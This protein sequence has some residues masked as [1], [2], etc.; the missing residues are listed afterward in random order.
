MATV[1]TL[2]AQRSASSAVGTLG[3]MGKLPGM[4]MNP[5]MATSSLLGTSSQT[6]PALP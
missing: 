4:G 6:T 5:M 3:S 2:S 1:G